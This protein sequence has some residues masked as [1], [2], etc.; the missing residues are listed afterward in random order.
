MP[1]FRD[2]S[3]RAKLLLAL[4]GIGGLSIGTI[5]WIGYSSA[6]QNLESEAF[7]KLAGVRANKANA[8]EEHLEDIRRQ[9]VTT[10]ENDR[11]VRAMQDFRSAFQVLDARGAA[12]MGGGGEAVRTYYEEEFLPRLKDR[13]GTSEP[14][15]AYVPDEGH[16]QYLQNKYIASNPNPVG[17]KDERTRPDEGWEVYHTTHAAYHDDFRRFLHAFNYYDLFLV[18]P[19]NGHIVYS[20]YKEV[21]FGTSLLDGPYQDSNFAEA[22]RAALEAGDSEEHRLVDFSAYAPSYGAPASF[23][24]S[25]I[26]DAGEVIGVLVFQMPIGE[27]NKTLTGGQDWQAEGLGETGETF[28]V[29]ADRRMRNDARSLLEDKDAYVKTLRGQGYDEATVD[30][31]DALNTTILQQTVQMDAVDRALSGETARTMESDYRG[32][33]VLSAYTPVDIEGVDWAVVSKIDRDEALAA[34][35]TLAWRIGL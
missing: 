3:V 30:R 21:D 17:E 5:G 7:G 6:Q 16:I 29:G 15:D 11:T 9:V 20:V 4:L 1:R 31:I 14:V 10:S 19:D 23:I 13:T 12:P 25:P 18:E 34:V 22:F 2:L 33:T 32:E 24:A 27:I 35:D 26:T 8:V 28:L